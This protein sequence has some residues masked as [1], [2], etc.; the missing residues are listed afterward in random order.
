MVD[1]AAPLVIG[2]PVRGGRW[3]CANGPAYNTAH[4]TLSV[5]DGRA[6]IPQ[7]FAFDFFKVDDA[8][9]R[10][11]EPFPNDITNSM[12][13]GYGAQV[14]AVADGVVERIVDGIPENVPQITGKIIMPVP[15][16][17]ETVSGNWLALKI[18]P[19]RW[20]FYAHLQP[21]SIR[22]K[23]GQRVKRGQLLGL[24]GDSGNAVGPHL[25]F[26]VGDAL[27][28]SLNATEGVP[29]VFDSY[30][31]GKTRRTRVLPRNNENITFP[32]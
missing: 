24:L 31:D 30:V 20:A 32:D 14:I 27:A 2:A 11:P 19:Q 23:V 15:L 4:Q 26:Q 1:P 16:T 18:A 8:G 25:H 7:R 22:V 9:H 10:L 21:G 5:I 6:R 28:E 29:F 13:F 3:N 12:F 17:K